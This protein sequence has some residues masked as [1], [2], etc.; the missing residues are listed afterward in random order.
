VKNTTCGDDLLSVIIPS[1]NHGRFVG[2][3]IESVLSQRYRPLELV[4]IDDGSTDDS[5]T[6]IQ[7]AVDEHEIDNVV[8]ETQDN[9]G[10]HHAINR[11]IELSSGAYL[12]ILNSDDFYCNH[13]FETLMPIALTAG[14]GVV[15]SGVRFVDDN[16]R[17]RST[18]DSWPQWYARCIEE[19]SRLPTTGYRL[20][21]HNFSVT[22]GNFLFRRELYE[23]LGGF[24]EHRFAH[25][26]DFLIRSVYHVEPVFV[27]EPLICY[28]VHGGNTTE[29][30]RGLM[31]VEC[32]RSLERYLR[33]F[34][35]PSPNPLAP[36]EENWPRFF[37]EF[38]K[39]HSA[40]FWPSGKLAELCNNNS[41]LLVRITE[42]AHRS[43]GRA[44]E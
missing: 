4:V 6:V 39:S 15:F 32:A 41:N 23:T 21:V 1:F 16:G 8:F 12:S 18:D 17:E 9:H 30:V 5:R 24:C 35:E 34:A 20:L 14:S 10:A 31:E 29:R 37:P 7:A 42:G 43:T 38:A 2:R 19:T 26:W 11:G 27:P 28:R 25:D 36:S 22:S 3:A 13:R 33:L 40:F 44:H